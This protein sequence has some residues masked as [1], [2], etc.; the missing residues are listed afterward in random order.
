VPKDTDLSKEQNKETQVA[1]LC[2]LLT[3]HETFSRHRGR[4]G[5]LALLLRHVLDNSNSPSQAKRLWNEL[6]ADGRTL[7]KTL[8]Q[9]D[10]SGHSAARKEMLT[11]LTDS[12][13]TFTGEEVPLSD[14]TAIT[15]VM[16][17]PVRTLMLLK[18]IMRTNKPSD[19][20][21]HIEYC[22]HPEQLYQPERWLCDKTLE[23][24]KAFPSILERFNSR[25]NGPGSIMTD[26][27]LMS[28]HCMDVL[29]RFNKFGG[30]PLNIAPNEQL[31]SGL[32]CVPGSFVKSLEPGFRKINEAG[33]LAFL[34]PGEQKEVIKSFDRNQQELVTTWQL[35]IPTAIWVEAEIEPTECKGY[36]APYIEFFA[37]SEQECHSRHNPSLTSKG[38]SHGVGVRWVTLRD[39]G[40]DP[41][42]L[43]K[44]EPFRCLLCS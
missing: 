5:K 2:E 32:S 8:A 19:L 9:L 31:V 23:L 42:R 16:P 35:R 3:G 26:G 22:E 17:D 28:S 15:I 34:I 14:T 37:E 11:A 25:Y 43:K 44:D 4:S 41:G 29:G 6:A 20:M 13:F 30:T 21:R 24:V 33:Q 10:R 7:L 12:N 38:V 40:V 39:S 18:W 36:G 27:V 1:E